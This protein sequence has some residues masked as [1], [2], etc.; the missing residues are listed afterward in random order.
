MFEGRSEKIGSRWT[1]FPQEF[2][3]IDVGAIRQCVLVAFCFSER[4]RKANTGASGAK[5]D[6]IA[7]F[8]KKQQA[9][10]WPEKLGGLE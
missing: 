6:A 3:L 5:K 9:A 7:E 4:W 8:T 1:N 10:N 2:F